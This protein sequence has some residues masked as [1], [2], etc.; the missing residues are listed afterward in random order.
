MNLVEEDVYMYQQQ[1]F[2]NKI[3]CCYVCELCKAIYGLRQAPTPWHFKHSLCLREL[4]STISKIDTQMFVLMAGK[5]NM[6]VLVYGDDIIAKKAKIEG[7]CPISTPMA[8][9]S[10][11]NVRQQH[12]SKYGR[13]IFDMQPELVLTL[14][15]LS[16]DFV[17]L[18]IDPH[19][20]SSGSCETDIKIPHD[21]HT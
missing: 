13:S 12:V 11:S 21:H 18:C 6:L 4:G 5:V 7:T 17:S 10:I 1:L 16:I 14:V 9:T 3:K 20:R 8:T 19:R 2:E 15:F